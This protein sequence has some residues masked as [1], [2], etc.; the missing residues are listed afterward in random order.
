MTA[1]NWQ[2]DRVGKRTRKYDL[3]LLKSRHVLS[4]VSLLTKDSKDITAIKGVWER[5]SLWKWIPV[6]GIQIS[7]PRYKNLQEKSKVWNLSPNG[8]R[9]GSVGYGTRYL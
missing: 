3:L 7:G 8:F 2:T 5:E 4:I 9:I 6:Q 1:H